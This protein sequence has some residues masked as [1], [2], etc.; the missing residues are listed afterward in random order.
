MPNYKIIWRAE[1][2]ISENLIGM[3]KKVYS[4]ISRGSRFFSFN[5]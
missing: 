4:R 1:K 5:W 2:E 3:R